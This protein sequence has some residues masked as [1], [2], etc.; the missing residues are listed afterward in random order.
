MTRSFVTRARRVLRSQAGFSLL[1]L[2]MAATLLGVVVIA[3]LAVADTSQKL[4]PKDQERA[5]AIRET[6]T[7][8]HQMTRE[9]R[10]AHAIVSTSP[11]AMTVRVLVNGVEQEVTYRCDQ[12]HPTNSAWKRC[13]RG[14]RLVVDRVLNNPVFEY[15]RSRPTGPITFVNAK[16]EVPAAG[17]LKDGHAHSIV[18]DDGFY[19]RNLNLR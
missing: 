14:T 11:T 13:L 2:T 9:L 4:A 8:L 15:T 16:V 19:M 3:I 7:G 10:Q 6:Q 18:L 12:P 17:D 5:H 1:E